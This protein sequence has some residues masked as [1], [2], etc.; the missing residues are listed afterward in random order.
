[1]VSGPLSRVISAPCPGERVLLKNGLPPVGDPTA[2]LPNLESN[3]R[4]PA[5][6]GSRGLLGG[7][8]AMKVLSNAENFSISEEIAEDLLTP[9]EVAA[10]LRIS[11]ETLR[12]L[13]LPYVR[14]G[15][16]TRRYDPADVDRFLE[17]KKVKPVMSR[18]PEIAAGI[19]ESVDR[20]FQEETRGVEA[21]RNRKS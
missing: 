17:Q 2:A 20:I 7:H 1:M 6:A 21:F 9:D 13:P 5:I 18:S 3:I 11:K 15:R 12:A 19:L 4:A 10:R 14:L 16:R 8:S